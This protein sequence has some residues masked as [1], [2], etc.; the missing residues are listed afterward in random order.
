MRMTRFNRLLETLL[1]GI[2][3]VGIALLMVGCAGSSKPV[4]VAI[5]PSAQQALDQGQSIAFTAAVAN[6]SS[7]AGV[8]WTVSGG[9]TLSNSTTTSVT[10]NAP[11]TVSTATTATL[12]A[13]S[14]K[15]TASTATVSITVNPAPAVT[16][17][18]L[19]AGV[20]GAAYSAQ[21]AGSGGTGA[22]TWTLGNG[23]LPPGLALST[24]G[25]IS[26]TPT[27]AGS[28]SFTVKVTDS[29]GTPLS[30]TQSLSIAVSPAPLVLTPPSSLT[31][32]IQ[33]TAY[34]SASFTASGGTGAI[35][36]SAVGLPAGL[37][38]SATT[39]A[40]I[41]IT[42]TP[43]AAG[44]SSIVVTATDSGTGA[45][46]Q[47]KS[48]AAMSLT[49]VSQIQSFAPSSFPAGVVNRVYAQGTTNLD[50]SGGTPPYTW[51][52][53]GLPAGIAC[54]VCTTT[55][56]A[57]AQI[58]G[59]PTVAGT[60]T[61]N[62][63]V[64]DSGA[65]A[66][67]QTASGSF[68]LMV[69]PQLTINA[70]S[71][72]PT[73][74]V[75]YAYAAT[76]ITATGGTTPVTWSAAGLPAGMSINAT[77]GVI[78][79]TP[80]IAGSSTATVTATDSGGLG[81]TQQTATATLSITINPALGISTT[82]LPSG[83]VNTAY[84][85]TLASNGGLAPV[86]W[87][88]SSGS[89]PAPLTLNASTG[90]ISGTPSAIG[91]STFT[92]KAT[93]SA[94]PAETASQTLSIT[95]NAA[96]LQILT[97][98]LP[99]AT[100]NQTYS[101]TLD[102]T[103]G[104]GA[105]TWSVSGAL[106]TGLTLTP[107]TGV[108]SGTPTTA[109]T[110]SFSVTATDSGTPQQTKTQSLSIVVNPAAA[111]LVINVSSLPGGS[112]GTTYSQSLN[113][114][115]GTPPYTASITSGNLPGGLT[116]NNN[117]TISGTP[118]TS[119]NFTFTAQF[120][121]SASP[122][123]TASKQLSIDIA[124]TP[125][126]ISSNGSVTGEV[127][128][129]F[130]HYMQANGGTQPYTW[131]VTPS[132][133]ALPSGLSLN[134]S[135][136]QI[137]GSPTVLG[138]TT[139]SMQVADSTS[140]TTTQSLAISV[141]AVRSNANNAELKGQYAFLLSGFDS[142]GNPI[143][144]AG[145]FTAD[146]AG[147]I[148]GGVEDINGTALAA[149][150]AN[151]SL[152][153]G[154]YSVG[155]DNRGKLTLTTA[156]GT[157]TFV[158]S[159]NAITSGVAHGGHIAEFDTSGQQFTGVLALQDATAFSNA[160]L[161]GGYAFGL[162]GFYVNS[163]QR[164]GSIGEMQFDS[165]GNITSAEVYTNV[166]GTIG[167][168]SSAT[169]TRTVGSNGRGTLSITVNG[170]ISHSVVY[171]VSANQSFVISSDPASGGSAM[172]LLTG[173]SLK[174]TITNGSFT[175]ASLNGVSVVGIVKLRNNG[176]TNTSDVQV[177]LITANGSGGASFS[178]DDNN[179]GTITTHTQT[180]ITY[181][182]AANGRV[183]MTNGGSSAPIFYL[184][185]LNQGFLMDGSIGVGTGYFEPQ[186]NASFTSTSLQGAY[187]F[188]TV[189][190]LLSGAGLSTGAVVADGAGNLSGTQDQNNSGELQ[191]DQTITATY[192]V[193]SN[194]RTTLTVPGNSN[195]PI[196]YIISPTKAMLLDAGSDPVLS[197]IEQ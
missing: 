174:Q 140:A 39:G 10:Y 28:S 24:S 101:A 188:G 138:N 1:S 102:S 55:A 105:I 94:N 109:G 189:T 49:V 165:S 89:L 15:A 86:T 128:L 36:W 142:T 108:I 99:N 35:N 179:D 149:P 163:G 117:G 158:I 84:S 135:T 77:T 139:V 129:P 5:T 27:T 41:A 176:T 131:S 191:P 164:A 91:T 79:G 111:T 123:Q 33:G 17:T 134:T 47:T 195:T 167:A 151:V 7:N 121:D 145:E 72:M 46:L 154:T 65:G 22:L 67:Q 50:A 59:T 155:T 29:A 83:S 156:S 168:P 186:T 26:G 125:L 63:T 122:P 127:S 80:T 141:S 130:G 159:L 76:T 14:V 136:G 25:A 133:P 69:I 12:T 143:A 71:T 103:G 54:S 152:T 148:S 116:I 120:Q 196:I 187:A 160:S 172:P 126:T 113:V 161:S 31:D 4:S 144:A 66:L 57:S 20:V 2:F 44:T 166:F 18:A 97:T 6:D 11:A 9:G 114:T 30:A 150:Q 173:Q 137:T 193:G 104:T 190:P 56:G 110:V 81:T 64:K 183:T 90:V 147:N 157:S 88:L 181:T 78:G 170:N 74:L 95:I 162:S 42:G 100:V 48:T 98:S 8:T 124:S 52:L 23:S 115:G 73:G 16:T 175:N 75:N 62:Y 82:T 106:P 118:T 119:G 13:T 146:G 184:V 37:R 112:V 93:D 132:T 197:I 21:L 194:G 19:A 58:A 60:S 38:L 70:P 171:V 34:T 169:G 96:P 68:T 61:V 177:G 43:A 32:A 192:T 107:S 185:G 85:A 87:S 182:V 3:A 153:S 40:S 92:V 51:T 53:T 180:G 45:F 178:A